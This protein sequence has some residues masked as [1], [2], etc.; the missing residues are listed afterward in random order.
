MIELDP[1]GWAMVL[2]ASVLIGITK[3]GI[4]GLGMLAIIVLAGAVPARLSTGLVLPVLIVGDIFAVAYYRR[5]AV[6]KHLLPLLPW[7]I[8]GIVPGYLI[9]GRLSD[10]QFRPI[11]GGMALVLIVLQHLH[12]RTNQRTLPFMETK[13]FA[14]VVGI[15]AGM[16]T[17]MANA[18][19]P[20]MTVY[21]LSMRLPKHEF[22]GT[23]AWYYLIVNCIKIPFS[24]NLGLINAESLKIDAAMCPM[25]VV[26]ALLGI[27]ILKRLPQ[28]QFCLI[29][30]LLAAAASIRLLF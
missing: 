3:T 20:I 9:L 16:V 30:E 17:M 19:G 5:H 15:L 22:V 21:L 11:I 2:T 13:W 29:A 4:P 27:L 25:I 28:K 18:A 7:A 1:A 8:V 24:A 10:A 6:W 26:G 12:R 14:A 23:G